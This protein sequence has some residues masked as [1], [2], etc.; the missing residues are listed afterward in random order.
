MFVYHLL[1]AT[2][3][4]VENNFLKSAIKVERNCY[5]YWLKNSDACCLG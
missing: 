4:E 1:K 2:D 5:G 3:T